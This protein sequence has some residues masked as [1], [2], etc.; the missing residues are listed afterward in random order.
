MKR[1]AA[2]ILSVFLVFVSL[3]MTAMAEDAPPMLRVVD[4]DMESAY[5]DWDFNKGYS[6]G[7]IIEKSSDGNEWVQV[8][9]VQVPGYSVKLAPKK[10]EYYRI[11]CYKTVYNSDTDKYV[12]FYEGASE[13][14]TLC[15][16]LNEASGSPYYSINSTKKKIL[17]TLE[18]SNYYYKY[19]SGFD[20]Y[21]GVNGGK[22]K[23][24]R[25]LKASKY[26]SKDDYY[27]YYTIKDTAPNKNAYNVK[28]L[29][30]PYFKAN[31]IKYDFR[32]DSNVVNAKYVNDSLVNA[33]TYSDK[34]KINLNTL[35]GTVKYKIAYTKYNRK[36]GKRYKTVTATTKKKSYTISGVSSKKYGFELS[37][38]PT[39]SNGYESYTLNFDSQEGT[40]L[41]NN[42]KKVKR[43]TIDVINTRTK[44][45][46]KH[47]TITLTK[48]EKKIIK[49]FFYKKY[50]GNNPSRAEMAKYAFDWIHKNVDYDYSYSKVTASCTESIFKKKAGQCLQ[51]NGAM[52]EVLTYL[53]YEAR[54]IEGYRA[55]KSGK[56]TVNHF[57]CEVKING[58][59][60][61]ME[62]GN[63]GKNGWWQ[64]Y[65]EPYRYGDGYTKN[66]KLVVPKA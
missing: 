51:Y 46:Y 23:Y 58:E 43:T 40:A 12:P 62:T 30:V 5:I 60:Y 57:W 29:F 41:M 36:S 34:V 45:S 11:N 48:S 18:Y 25:T 56:P 20:I 54:V 7:A 55:N 4:N 16:D 15:P 13:P 37:I 44:K 39:W 8:A 65:C 14:A 28:Y 22:L 32:N 17:L 21:K 35:G 64:H 50:K 47:W 6:D 9:N 3:P 66:G 31:G 63:E 26:K 49:D 59:W 61:L 24:Y 42:P 52:A 2:V 53:G 10:V 38:T 27:H 1:I 33:V 19:T